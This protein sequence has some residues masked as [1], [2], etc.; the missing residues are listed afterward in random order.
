MSNFLCLIQFAML[1]TQGCT[2]IQIRTIQ[3]PTIQTLKNILKRPQIKTQCIF[4]E[5]KKHIC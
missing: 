4:V 3:I 2:T 1:K 5:N